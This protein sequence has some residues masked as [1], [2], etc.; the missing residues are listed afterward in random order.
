[1]PL[2]DSQARA[3]A[4]VADWASRPGRAVIFDFNGTLSDDEPILEA[5]F[6]EI[7]AE[8][9]GWEMSPAE[10][11]RDLLGHSDREIVQRAVRTHGDGDYAWSADKVEELLALRRVR[12]LEAVSEHSPISTGAAELVQ[13]LGAAG[14]PMGVVTGAQR[15]DVLAVLDNS[16]VGG[17]ISDLVT[18]EDVEHGKPH[19]E[20]FLKGAALLDVHPADVLVFEDSVPGVRAAERAGMWCIAVTGASPDPA[21]LQLAL[22][23]VT[24]LDA[25]LLHGTDL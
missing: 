25:T 21:V 22:A 24:H 4:V 9:L 20:G 7:F 11:R 2:P 5:I 19:P 13:R 8:H 12:Y 6:T 17:A 3:A 23:H 18:E 1:M 10:Y 14:I 16:V 15:A